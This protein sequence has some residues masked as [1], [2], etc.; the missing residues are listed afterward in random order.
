MDIY[1]GAAVQF[2][3]EI[4]DNTALEITLMSEDKVRASFKTESLIDIKVND[5]IQ[6]NFI[7]YIVMKPP[8]AAR[9]KINE[10]DYSVEFMGRMHRLERVAF[11]LDGNATFVYRGNMSTL[12]DLIRDNGQR[13][14]GAGFNAVLG[15][16]NNE[17]KTIDFNNLNTL[18]AIKLIAETYGV[19]F[20]FYQTAEASVRFVAITGDQTVVPP[21]YG[22]KTGIQTASLKYTNQIPITTRLYALGGERNIEF[23]T[24]GSKRL[25]LP[26][27]AY[28]DNLVA[29]HGVIER[30]E[31][32]DE[33][34]PRRTGTV[35]SIIN[36]TT[37]RD[38]GMDFDLNSQ[39]MAEPAK[40][41]FNTGDLA[42]Y[43]FEITSYDNGTKEFVI[44]TL[45]DDQDQTLPNATL[46]PSTNDEYVLHD[47]IM[48]ASYITNAETELETIA[49]ARVVE[50]S[51][52]TFLIDVVMDDRYVRDNAL[53]FEIGDI[54]VT[55]S[56]LGL[57][58]FGNFRILR[59][60]QSIANQDKYTFTVGFEKSDA[61]IKRIQRDNAESQRL[62]RKEER[63]RLADKFR[64]R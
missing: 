7:D 36:T 21:G 41:T 20:E 61:I 13:V 3:V 43:S 1:R 4:G 2:S 18:D 12:V 28:R 50:L 64:N 52:Q 10:Y 46:N 6:I 60:V 53:S 37:F 29:T 26:G 8:S 51:S 19:E 27:L 57:P 34:Y 63:E 22:L 62:I 14:L 24:Y 35:T 25:K 15:V 30:V 45:T 59:M 32:F 54:F 38:T 31:I 5:Y 47:I 42:G 9:S 44:A 49:D 16:V 23:S 55:N 58:F 39:L 17:I 48:P 11:L 56:G 33:V 40:I